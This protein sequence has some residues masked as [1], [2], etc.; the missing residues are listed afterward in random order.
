VGLSFQEA[1]AAVGGSGSPFEVIDVELDGPTSRL[2]KNAPSNLRQFFDTARGLDETFIVYEDEE[3]TFAEV[4][5]DVDAL[6]YALVHR[7]GVAPGDRVGIAM[8]NYPV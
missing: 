8:R 3:W 5:E 4:M 2:F 6:G 7:F 1:N